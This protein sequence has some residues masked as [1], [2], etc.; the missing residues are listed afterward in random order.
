MREQC[1]I[2]AQNGSVKAKKLLPMILLKIEL[3]RPRMGGY[4]GKTDFLEIARYKNNKLLE[5]M[6]EK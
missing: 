3:I 4:V 6:N 5:E 1:I 2:L